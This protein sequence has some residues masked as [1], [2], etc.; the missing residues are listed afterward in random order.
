MPCRR[1]E[2]VA[3]ALAL[4]LLATCSGDVTTELASL[5]PDLSPLMQKALIGDDHAFDLLIQQ[6]GSQPVLSAWWT[7]VATLDRTGNPTDY[8]NTREQITP[9][10]GRI[11]REMVARYDCTYWTRERARIGSTD[12]SSWRERRRVAREMT[13][14]AAD[15]TLTPAERAARIVALLDEADASGDRRL[16]GRIRVVLADAYA[17]ANMNEESLRSRVQAFQRYQHLGLHIEACQEA[18]AIGGQ[19]EVMGMPDST[20]RYYDFART[21]AAAHDL[22]YH[23][24]RISTFY[25]HHFRR[26]GR[27][28]LA[29]QLYTDALDAY[30]PYEFAPG[31]LRFV[32]SAAR[33]YRSLGTLGISERLLERARVL[34][35]AEAQAG[36]S[37]DPAVVADYESARGLHLLRNGRIEEASALLQRA[38]DGYQGTVRIAHPAQLLSQWAAGLLDAGQFD[39]ARV[40]IDRGVRLCQDPTLASMRPGFYL[41]R[42][43][44]LLGLDRLEDAQLSLAAF[45][46]SAAAYSTR[47]REEWIRRDVIHTRLVLA[48]RGRRAALGE[49]GA[50][51]QRMQRSVGALDAESPTVLWLSQRHDLRNL[52]RELAGNDIDLAYG[53]ELAWRGIASGRR[54]ATE[55]SDPATEW[56]RRSRDARSR[57]AGDV[58]HCLYAVAADSAWRYDASPDGVTRTRLSIAPDTL[59]ALASEAWQAMR[60]PP[61]GSGEIGAALERRLERL[62]RELLPARILGTDAAAP[63]A[64]TT[65]LVTADGALGSIPFSTFDTDEGD[66]YHPLIE[67]LDVAY[68]RAMNHPATDPSPPR[69][70]VVST[71]EVSAPT[72]RRMGLRATLDDAVAEAAEAA[73]VLPSAR[74]LHGPDATRR[75]VID[76]WEDAAYLYVAAHVLRDADAPFL[77]LLPLASS[78]TSANPR[79]E[80]L[81]TGDILAADLSKCR[82]VVLSG[83]S[84]GAPYIARDGTGPSL[85]DAFLDAGAGAAVQTFWDVEDGLARESMSVF[86]SYWQGDGHAPVEALGEMRRE[87]RNAR[88]HPG[89]W[90]AYSVTLGRL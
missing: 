59:T 43:D 64:I 81:D 24:A 26:V 7:I 72:A 49:L 56:R 14:A 1:L 11:A 78:P 66:A 12:F 28:A 20:A 2:I 35:D 3:L 53:A 69:S 45:D 9:Y 68:V 83:C 79:D 61:A 38:M 65:L 6:V 27:I 10:L 44:A 75:A 50:S 89:Y 23:S 58:L 5:C 52:M 47:A 32:L 39:Q 62:A 15:G 41:Q 13:V 17:R 57:L 70:L 33:F 74:R 37:L 90:A 8:E 40:V 48:A 21:T 31:E 4:A 36:G 34:L 51:L 22:P 18:G 87:R 84:T 54:A 42:A 46:S 73:R 29:H 86:L 71:P 16:S 67:T 30:L 19:Y 25:A 82:V 60:N 76:A 63:T 85:G 80:F 88:A 55:E 77:T